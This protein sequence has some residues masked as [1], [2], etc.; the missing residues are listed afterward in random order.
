MRSWTEWHEITQST[1]GELYM[2][3][4]HALKQKS[5]WMVKLHVYTVSVLFGF[6]AVILICDLKKPIRFQLIFSVIT[7][8]SQICFQL[9]FSVVTWKTPICFQLIILSHNYPH[10]IDSRQYMYSTLQQQVTWR[11]HNTL[12]SERLAVDCPWASL[13]VAWRTH[14]WWL[15]QV[16]PQVFPQ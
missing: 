11:Y 6:S 14:P 3:Y 16:F 12:H 2:V 5:T 10:S 7:W 13:A 9:W 15:C 1:P 8:I 4:F